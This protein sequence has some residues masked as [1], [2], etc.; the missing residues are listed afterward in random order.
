MKRSGL[1]IH[2]PFC[3]RKCNYCDFISYDYNHELAE[4]FLLALFSEFKLLKERYDSP[5]LDTVYFGGGTP[6]CLSGEEL[7]R[8]LEEVANTFSIA[9]G[10]EITCEMN[11]ATGLK[12]DLEVMKEAG[13]NR[14]S[15]GVQ[16]FD[17]ET[18]NYLGRVHNLEQIL[19][20]YR[21]ARQVG[22]DNINLDLIFAIPG[23]TKEGWRKSLKEVLRLNP[24]H[25]S[26]YNLKIEEDTPF[27]RMLE[28]DEL[29]PADEDIEYWMYKEAIDMLEEAGFEHYEISNF[30]RPG[31]RSRHNMGYWQYKPYLAAGPAAHGFDGKRRYYNL[32]HLE[33]YRDHLAKGRLPWVEELELSQQEQMEEYLFMGLR[34]VDGIDITDFEKRFGKSIYQIYGDRIKKLINRQLLQLNDN[35]LSLTPEGFFLGN[36]VFAEFLL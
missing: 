32:S 24:E 18:L 12:E 31:H 25:L 33:D 27:Y 23:Q 36:E 14:L 10:A 7:A 5:Q 2:I 22:F 35:R 34:V 20:T 1:Y 8:I 4:E 15:I 6:T 17:D 13:F 29:E 26:L 16:A 28:A 9:E 30:A 21:L 11:P 19:E 3:L